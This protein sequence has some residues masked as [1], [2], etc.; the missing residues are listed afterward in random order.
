MMGNN[1]KKKDTGGRKYRRWGDELLPQI[2]DE[3]KGKMVPH[4]QYPCVAPPMPPEIAAIAA[5][6]DN[7]DGD[8]DEPPQTPEIRA[9][10]PVVVTNS[11]E[12]HEEKADTTAMALDSVLST[13]DAMVLDTPVK[14][15]KKTA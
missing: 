7:D 2:W 5:A 3:A 14:S 10:K 11:V 4:L 15:A 13:S 1:S 12:K 8:G 9:N 6:N